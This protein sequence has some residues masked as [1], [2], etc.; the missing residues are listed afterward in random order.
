MDNKFK[1]LGIHCGACQKVIEKKLLK[2]EGVS[3]VNAEANGDVSVLANR[4]IN[5]DEVKLALEGTEY[6]VSQ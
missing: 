2:V 4:A 1:V 6:T 5:L 3:Q